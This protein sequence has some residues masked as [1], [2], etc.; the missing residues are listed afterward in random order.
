MLKISVLLGGLFLIGCDEA[1]TAFSVSDGSVQSETNTSEDTSTET[2]EEEESSALDA[3]DGG[4]SGTATLI[5][6]DIDDEVVPD[7]A[8]WNGITIHDS[9]NLLI[10]TMQHKLLYLYHYTPKLEQIGSRVLLASDL[11]N[12]TIA[13]H[14]QA[15][16]NGVLYIA[17]SDADADDLYLMAVSTD[18]DILHPIQTVVSG[19]DSVTNDMHLLADEDG[20]HLLWGPPGYDRLQQSFDTSLAPM[21]ESQKLTSP[22]RSSQLG[23][24]ISF[25]MEYLVF[26]GDETN[27]QV[28]ITRWGKDWSLQA[29][30]EIVVPG[31]T[32]WNWFPS[33]VA[34][35]E[36]SDTWFIAYT[37]MEEDESADEDASIRLATLDG[38]MNLL[39][40]FDVTD[41][42]GYTRPHL[43]LSGDTLYL[44]YDGNEVYI[45]AFAIEHD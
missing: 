14:A 36:S 43:A 12:S 21:S 5:D 22:V 37:H 41:K 19:S 33:G 17:L 32:S 23:T 45:K 9:G 44:T 26:S 25:G 40:V 24:T 10:T 20:V 8:I 42:D 39:D 13:D 34:H 35:H 2:M 29:S 28:M 15:L 7:A 4:S 1:D 30:P 31:N 16:Y 27:R 38:D 6:A 18:G 11:P 3:L